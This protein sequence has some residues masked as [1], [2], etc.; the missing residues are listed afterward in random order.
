LHLLARAKK[1]GLGKAYLA[2]FNWGIEAGF[3]AIIE[4][5]ADFSHR[6]VDLQKL[7]VCLTILRTFSEQK[8]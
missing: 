6:P 8:G 2:G 4:M 1:E 3:D 7:F 5:D